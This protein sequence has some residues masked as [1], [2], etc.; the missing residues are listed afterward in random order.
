MKF[1]LPW[2]TQSPKRLYR[3]RD[4]L[5][6]K[7]IKSGKAADKKK[8]LNLKHLVKKNTKLAY[9]NYLQDILNIENPDDNPN[10]KHPN[11]KKLYTLLK[12]SR[13]DSSSVGP[14]KE[15]NT[16]SP[17]SGSTQSCRSRSDP[18]HNS[19]ITGKRTFTY[20]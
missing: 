5:Y 16:P 12:H 1:D 14:L 11:T 19:Q 18:T 4:R 13:Q 3:R 17:E 10:N 15:G 7:H 6:R 9:Q 20:S 2:V 8:Y